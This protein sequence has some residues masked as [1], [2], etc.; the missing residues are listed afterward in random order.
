M[1]EG[2]GILAGFL[3]IYFW[4]VCAF[5]SGGVAQAK[6]RS[7]ILWFIVGLLFGLFG[8]IAAAG[9]PTWREEVELYEWRDS[10][11]N[12]RPAHHVRPKMSESVA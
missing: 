2:V 10:R 6:G 5:L 7:G 4:L 3:A 1:I 8:L 12:A 11:R 9:M